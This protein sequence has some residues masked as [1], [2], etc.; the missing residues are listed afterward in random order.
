MNIDY[1]HKTHDADVESFSND[2][3]PYEVYIPALEDTFEQIIEIRNTLTLLQGE[4]TQLKLQ[5]SDLV[6]KNN[7]EPQTPTVVLSKTPGL[8]RLKK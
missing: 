1:T 8:R 5:M 6:F 2:S 7:P 3:K 4:I